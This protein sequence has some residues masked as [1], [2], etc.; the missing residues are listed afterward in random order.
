MN[1][2]WHKKSEAKSKIQKSSNQVQSAGTEEEI[3][4]D[5]WVKY[6]F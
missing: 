4:A 5:Q 2:F 1:I 6:N 3:I